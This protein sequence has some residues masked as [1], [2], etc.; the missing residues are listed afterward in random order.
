[1]R[2]KNERLHLDLLDMS[3][4]GL[5]ARCVSH[6]KMREQNAKPHSEAWAAVKRGCAEG[7][8]EAT[9]KLAKVRE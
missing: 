5:S 2:T 6:S 7:N 4:L 1:M 3:L 9:A 8:V